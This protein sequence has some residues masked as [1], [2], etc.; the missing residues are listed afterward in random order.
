MN[1]TFETLQDSATLAVD[2][3]TQE[4]ESG[5]W[6]PEGSGTIITVDSE[7]A[8][9]QMQSIVKDRNGTCKI[10]VQANAGNIKM[11]QGRV[12]AVI[13]NDGQ[14]NP[15]LFPSIILPSITPNDVRLGVLNSAPGRD[16]QGQ[17]YPG[18]RLSADFVIS[19]EQLFL[20]DRMNTTEA[21]G[22]GAH[23]AHTEKVSVADIAH[24]GVAF[25]MVVNES[26]GIDPHKTVHQ[27]NDA[28]LGKGLTLGAGLYSNQRPVS[29]DVVANPQ[30]IYWH[31]NLAL[32]SLP[33]LPEELSGSRAV[34]ALGYASL[35][36][37]VPKEKLQQ[38][39]AEKLKAVQAS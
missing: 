39:I 8:I 24:S 25:G 22:A 1:H 12:V 30:A 27:V 7:I 4:T 33:E 14:G 20:L 17:L 16:A 32:T 13:A 29:Q 35:L 18:D 36:N 11:L 5:L 23:D 37:S 21:I 31:P 38:R 34:L 3:V 9:S 10:P 26:W 28:G 2:V 19:E 6:T 15:G